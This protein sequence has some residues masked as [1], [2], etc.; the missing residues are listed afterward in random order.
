MVREKSG[1]FV[2]FLKSGKSQGFFLNLLL[3]SIFDNVCHGIH[4]YESVHVNLQ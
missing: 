4:Q 3:L 2:S 1:N